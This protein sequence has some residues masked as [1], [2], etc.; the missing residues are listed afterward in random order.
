[1]KIAAIAEKI[2]NLGKGPREK[3]TTIT[4]FHEY[5]K[6]KA[7]LHEPPTFRV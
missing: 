4:T 3:Q 5:G 7:Y 2:G 1:M 6:F